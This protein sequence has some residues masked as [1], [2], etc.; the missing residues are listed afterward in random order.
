MQRSGEKRE[1]GGERQRDERMLRVGRAEQ[2]ESRRDRVSE[3]NGE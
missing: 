3:G 1:S 2:R